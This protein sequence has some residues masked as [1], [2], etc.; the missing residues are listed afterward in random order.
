MC[1]FAS[2]SL[3]TQRSKE[4]TCKGHS[5]S[6]RN[7]RYGNG[8]VIIDDR[9]SIFNSSLLLG[10]FTIRQGCNEGFHER[11]WLYMIFKIAVC[12][13]LCVIKYFGCY[14]TNKFTRGLQFRKLNG[15]LKP[16]FLCFLRLHFICKSVCPKPTL[17]SAFQS[18]KC[19]ELIVATMVTPQF[20]VGVVL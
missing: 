13:E 14:L 20:T 12:V 19:G 8:K 7:Y 5:L 2:V 1:E 17:I 18:R 10:I 11:Y 3:Y 15:L 4:L 6:H 9:S 16:I